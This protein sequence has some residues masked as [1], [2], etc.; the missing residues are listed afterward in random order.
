LRPR[1]STHGILRTRRRALPCVQ[2]Q[3]CGADQ[4]GGHVDGGR[5]ADAVAMP[6]V[7]SAASAAANSWA[8]AT[9]DHKLKRVVVVVRAVAGAGAGPLAAHWA[10]RL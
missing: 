7:T 3:E 1:T 9:A 4:S 5:E 8:V 6:S 10:L 2:P